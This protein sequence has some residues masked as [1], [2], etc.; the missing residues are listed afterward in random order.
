LIAAGV[1]GHGIHAATITIA[2]SVP[3]G[4]PFDPDKIAELFWTAHTDPADV[5]QTAYR[6]TGA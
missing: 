2:G 4:T 5:W 6:F 1:K 3:R